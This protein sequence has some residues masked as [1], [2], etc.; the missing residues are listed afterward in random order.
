L[1]RVVL[2]SE[3]RFVDLLD[4]TA[5]FPGEIGGLPDSGARGTEDPRSQGGTTLQARDESIALVLE[6]G[7]F[8]VFLQHVVSGRNGGGGSVCRCGVDN[9][10]SC[11]PASGAVDGDVVEHESHAALEG[12]H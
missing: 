11:I 10:E 2:E 6:P 12:P 5:E 4:P 8:L 9:L 3:H 1:R 7:E